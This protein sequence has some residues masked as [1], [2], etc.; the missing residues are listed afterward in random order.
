MKYLLLIFIKAYWFLI[1]KSKRKKCIF[2]VSCSNH[3]YKTAMNK[4]FIAG[5][6][7]FKYRFYNCRHGYEIFKNPVNNEMQ[8]KLRNNEVLNQKDIA[9][10]FL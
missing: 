8:I 7:A 2:R 1:P 4:G 6:K 10:R 3:V 5:C 9:E